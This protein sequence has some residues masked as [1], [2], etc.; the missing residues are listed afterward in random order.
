MPWQGGECAARR[1]SRPGRR[2]R[3]RR[4]R[5]ARAGTRRTSSPRARSRAGRGVR[6]RGAA[7]EAHRLRRASSCTRRTATCCTSSSRRLRTGATT[8]TARTACGSRSRWRG[9][10]AMSG[11]RN[12]RSAPHHGSDWAEGGLGR[13]TTRWRYARELE[14]LGFDYVCVSG[15]ALVAAREDPGGA[16]LPGAAS[17]RRSSKERASRCAPSA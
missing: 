5:S 15:G 7:R 2:S 17:P 9:R 11:R 12:G 13:P 1:P 6:R 16:R 3:R 14:G 10:C 4:F 8:T